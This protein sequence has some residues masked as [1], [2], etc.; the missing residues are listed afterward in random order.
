MSWHR[1]LMSQ[2]LEMS[3]PIEAYRDPIPSKAIAKTKPILKK[4]NGHIR[5]DQ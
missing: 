2:P 4:K 5:T 1:F 3:Q